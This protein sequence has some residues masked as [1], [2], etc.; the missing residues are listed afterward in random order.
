M[1]LQI[2][3]FQFNQHHRKFHLIKWSLPCTWLCGQKSEQFNEQ[4]HPE[5]KYR[6]ANM[7]FPPASP[8]ISISIV[9]FIDCWISKLGDAAQI[10]WCG[11]SSTFNLPEYCF[12][13]VA[14]VQRGE[15]DDGKLER[16]CCYMI[17]LL[18]ASFLT[19][20]QFSLQSKAE[21]ALIISAEQGHVHDCEV[22]K[23]LTSFRWKWKV[24][25]GGL[26]MR[27][28]NGTR[29]KWEIIS[30]LVRTLLRSLVNLN[31]E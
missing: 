23:T 3:T 17:F 10:R 15:R 16:K 13:G 19:P 20:P 4:F 6:L 2:L 1:K 27:N 12:I 25:G 7:W 11:Q 31:G 22:F 9:V 24:F 21:N 26:A 8:F 29:S 5:N 18:R 28:N 30:K 14:G